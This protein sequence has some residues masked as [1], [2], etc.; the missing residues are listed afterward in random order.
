MLAKWF[1]IGGCQPFLSLDVLPQT[2]LSLLSLLGNRIDLL[3]NNSSVLSIIRVQKEDPREYSPCYRSRSQR[4]FY[5]GS[6][7]G[8][9]LCG[10]QP[11]G[12]WKGPYIR[13]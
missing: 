3:G 9:V 2:R 11:E 13:K 6:E 1:G 5:E 12:V 4:S 10:P 8:A 7:E